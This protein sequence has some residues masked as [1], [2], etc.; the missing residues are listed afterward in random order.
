MSSGRS[1]S[2]TAAGAVAVVSIGAIPFVSDFP[3]AVAALAYLAILATGRTR[4]SW[5]GKGLA[6]RIVRR[7]VRVAI[8]FV[9]VPFVATVTWSGGVVESLVAVAFAF[10]LL[11]PDRR[12]IVRELSPARLALRSYRSGDE[13][14]RDF[15]A[16]AGAGVAQEYFYRGVVLTALLPQ[17][18]WF[19]I[20][21]AAAMFVF[22]HVAQGGGLHFDRRDLINQTIMSIVFGALAIHAGSVLP[23]VIGHTVY[24]L[25]NVIQIFVRIHAQRSDRRIRHDG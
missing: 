19:A 23:A 17:L 2:A 5:L 25:P 13:P 12:N 11:A 21:P 4:L 6:G 9:P 20:L 24:N 7:L 14:L 15:I 3:V 18:G 10:A 16:F 1:R 22:E 8:F